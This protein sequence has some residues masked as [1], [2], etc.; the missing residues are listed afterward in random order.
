ME[1]SRP[2]DWIRVL[3]LVPL[4]FVVGAAAQAPLSIPNGLPS[5]AFNIPD[6]VQPPT[7]PVTGP[8][9]VPGSSKEY[10]AEKV[11]SSANPPD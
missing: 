2:G 8:V 4:F 9:H 5:W 10:D 7:V 6:K 3:L 1:K 11:A